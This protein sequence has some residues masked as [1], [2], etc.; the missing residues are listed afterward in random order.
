MDKPKSN[1][2][3][4]GYNTNAKHAGNVFHVQTEDSGL[5]HP[6]IITH[7]FTEGTILATKKRSY[8]ELVDDAEWQTKV[9]QLMKEQHKEMLI[10]L[11]DGVH[12][13]AA[14]RILG[15]PPSKEEPVPKPVQPPAAVGV[16][17]I[18]PSTM[19]SAAKK[20]KEEKPK[21]AK[22]APKGRSI[23]SVP[24]EQGDFGENLMSDKSLD[25]VIFSFLESEENDDKG[26]G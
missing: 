16:K 8:A 15:E 24:D 11:R 18:L 2:P 19:V 22:S 1:S 26:G 6:H 10:E 3:L 9:R 7:L 13:A 14:A 21:E 17:V 5:D 25:E 12:D 23:F 4:L 20:A